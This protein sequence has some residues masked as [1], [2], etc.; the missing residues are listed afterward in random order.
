MTDKV[1][2]S[3]KYIETHTDLWLSDHCVNQF[4]LASLMLPGDQ[5]NSSSEAEQAVLKLL[6][7]SRILLRHNS[8]AVLELLEAQASQK[9]VD[10]EQ[11]TKVR[12]YVWTKVFVTSYMEA[13]S[14]GDWHKCGTA[15]KSLSRQSQ[16]IA[17]KWLKQT[18]E[19]TNIS[20]AKALIVTGETLGPLKY[21]T[22]LPE[23]FLRLEIIGGVDCWTQVLFEE[24]DRL[25]TERD[26]ILQSLTQIIS[27]AAS[28]DNSTDS[29]LVCGMLSIA[30]RAVLDAWEEKHLDQ[31][32]IPRDS[33]RAC[34][35][36]V[37][38]KISNT[39]RT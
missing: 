11:Q 37:M 15:W 30:L 2:L 19:Y 20:I 18:T 12:D 25:R 13:H 33:V 24:N 5:Q 6:D 14:Q 10:E 22:L 28:L 7:E 39:L 9:S 21:I 29:Q 3:L 4:V 32:E 16:T 8:K 35:Q 23:T 17:R 1:T 31:D 27:K 34:L 26:L 38:G 36:Q